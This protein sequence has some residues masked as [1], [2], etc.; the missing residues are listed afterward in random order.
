MGM[1][2]DPGALTY[3][4]ISQLAGHRAGATDVACPSCGPDRRAPVNQRRKVLRVWR[5]SPTF[6]TYRC[7]RCDLHGY[8]REDG[9]SAPDPAALAKARA[10]AQRFGAETAEAKRR[11]AQWLWGRR[12]PIAGTPAERYLREVRRYGGPIPATMGFLP[13]RGEFTP[14]MISAFGM[15]HEIEPGVIGA[16]AAI[17]GVHLTRLAPDGSSKAGT[18]A[19]K[20]MLGTPRG[21]PIA[22]A[23]V[24]DLLGL[25]ITEGIED[26]LSV[27]EATGLGV[28]AAGSASFMPAL[29]AMV[30]AY[31]EFVTI[32]ADPDPDGRRF[33]S[34]L[35]ARLAGRGLDH[36]LM[37]WGDGERIAA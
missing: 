9:A 21:A 10:E 25:A 26:A 2:A 1:V 30:P 22:L 6:V 36:R 18:E 37:V 20:I 34:E 19:D 33:A 29:A 31:V 15:P 27:H 16:P 11:K 32:V 35:K 24:G 12:Q 23:A 4:A 3:R 28:W 13:A 14:A 7:A 5:V 17:Q 8:A